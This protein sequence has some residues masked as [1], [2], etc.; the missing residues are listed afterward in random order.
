[1][2]KITWLGEDEYH[3]GVAGPSFCMGPGGIKFPKDVPIEV[4]DNAFIA[5][6]RNNRFFDVEG[7]DEF[8][9]MHSE[10]K[11]RGRPPKVKEL[12]TSE[13]VDG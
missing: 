11:R 13:A 2:A 8:V 5:K 3:D 6:A 7:A 12:E 1:M 10:P 4:T 9:S